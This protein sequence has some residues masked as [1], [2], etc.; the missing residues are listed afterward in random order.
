MSRTAT[1]GLI[2]VG[3]FI[4]QAFVQLSDGK[5]PV[6]VVFGWTL[7]GVLIGAACDAGSRPR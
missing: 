4:G 3:G 7:T 2:M 6:L 1:Q 5:L